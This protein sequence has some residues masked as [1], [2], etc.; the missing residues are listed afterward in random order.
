MSDWLVTAVQVSDSLKHG[1]SYIKLSHPRREEKPE[2]L[3]MNLTL[4]I[5]I[6]TYLN[7]KLDFGLKFLKFVLN[8]N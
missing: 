3:R 5:T 2:K 1:P 7:I 6:A 8:L 4:S